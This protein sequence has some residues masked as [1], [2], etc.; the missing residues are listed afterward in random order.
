MQWQISK[1][2]AVNFMTLPFA[3]FPWPALFFIAL[4]GHYKIVLAF[5][6]FELNL[7]MLEDGG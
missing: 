1:K 3:F 6:F 4:P 2:T 7:T 5:L